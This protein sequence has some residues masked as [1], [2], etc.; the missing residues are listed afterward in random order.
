VPSSQLQLTFKA[1]DTV[2]P[3]LNKL[4]VFDTASLAKFQGTGLSD[5]FIAMLGKAAN[6][7]SSRSTKTAA[8][9]SIRSTP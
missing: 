9:R 4:G 1:F 8:C 3:N 5:D 2:I 6:L 7:A